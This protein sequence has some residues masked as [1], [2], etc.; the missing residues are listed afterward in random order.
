MADTEQNKQTDF[1]I[2]KIK[3]RPV[4]KK[5]LLRKTVTTASMA[6]IFGLI[7]CLTFLILEPVFSNWLYPEEEPQAVVFPEEADE[8]APEDMLV[9]E[10]TPSLQEAVESVIL[11]EE[12]IQKILDNIQLDKSHYLQLYNAMSEYVK[13]LNRSM[14]VVTG[15][16]SDVDFLNDTYES[17]GQSYGVLVACN[18]KDYLVLTEKKV[19]DQAESISVTFS[20]GMKAEAEIKQSDSQTGLAVISVPLSSLLDSTRKAVK[21]AA[22]GTSNLIEPVGTPVVAL[23]SPMGIVESVGYGMISSKGNSFGMVDANY[24]LFTTDIY[25]GADGTGILFDLQNHI[26]GV[27]TE[28]RIND[29]LANNITAIGVSELR[30]LVE[31]MS[32]GKEPAYL[33]ISGMDVTDEANKELGVPFGAYVKEVEMGSPAMLAGIQKGDVIVDI[34]GNSIESFSNY[35]TTLLRL[36]VGQVVKVILQRPVQDT[37]REMEMEIT[38]QTAK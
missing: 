9:L 5:K 16:T 38:L 37:Y 6:V 33:G 27:I 10:E 30:K 20:D 7:A 26:I 15:V 13:E 25:G 34:G 14:V 36:E 28:S 12:Q 29:D 22:L 24:Q 21:M 3:E 11:E 19:I 32:N 23:G 4:N 8:M 18:G 31:N 35:A 1:M 17:Q 2:E